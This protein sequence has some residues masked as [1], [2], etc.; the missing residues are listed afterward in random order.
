ME[1][2]CEWEDQSEL[3]SRLRLVKS[4]AEIEYVRQAAAL[5]DEAYLAAQRTAIRRERRSRMCWPP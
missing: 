4:D 5:A 2:K 1:G 3:V